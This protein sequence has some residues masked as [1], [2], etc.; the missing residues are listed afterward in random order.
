MPDTT[1]STGVYR[2]DNGNDLVVASGGTLLVESGGTLT[3][4]GN[5]VIDSTAELVYSGGISITTVDATITDVNVI[6]GTTTGTKIGTAVGQKLGFW[7][8]TPVIQQAS[9]NQA[10]LTAVTTAGSN[11]T[12]SGAGL[13]LIGDTTSVNQA[14]AI[15]A[16]FTALREDV[17]QMSVL[18]TAIRTALVTTGLIKGAV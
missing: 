5:A 16:D 12:A 17:L 4:D 13:S 10:A 14:A 1:Y 9:A 15:M 8:A 2:T 18:L 11:V 3:C 7:N 6:L